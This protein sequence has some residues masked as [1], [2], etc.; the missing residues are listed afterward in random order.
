MSAVLNRIYFALDRAGI[1]VG[2]ISY[3]VETRNAATPAEEASPADILRRTPIFRL[4]EDKDLSE[5]AAKLHRL[6]F[7]P[8]EHILRQGDP[9]DS[10]YFVVSGR[11]SIA[12]RALVM[13]LKPI[14]LPSNRATSSAKPRC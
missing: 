2:E 6:S 9:G 11:V 7:A 14:W 4:L 1:P 8:G 5:L 12:Y 10:M 3:L 13:A